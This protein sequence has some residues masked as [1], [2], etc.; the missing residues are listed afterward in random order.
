LFGLYLSKYNYEGWCLIKDEDK[1]RQNYI[2]AT[3]NKNL[4]L[5]KY[6]KEGAVIRDNLVENL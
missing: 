1:L 5:E 3:K 4:S 2:R 6:E